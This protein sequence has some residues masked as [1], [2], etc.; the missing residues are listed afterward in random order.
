[1]PAWRSTERVCTP[2][3]CKLS[4]A[5]TCAFPGSVPAQSTERVCTLPRCKLYTAGSL[6]LARTLSTPGAQREF[7]LCP[8][9]NFPKQSGKLAPCPAIVPAWSSTERVCTRPRC[10]L[11]RA[12]S[13]RLA[14]P[15]SLPRAQRRFGPRPT[16]N[17][18][19][20]EARVLPGLSKLTDCFCGDNRR[21]AR[22]DW[23]AHTH[24]QHGAL[25]SSGCACECGPVPQ[26]QAQLLR[27]R[28][29]QQSQQ[30]LNAHAHLLP[31]SARPLTNAHIQTPSPLSYI[32]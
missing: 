2:S 32:K 5:G 3:C 25:S 9:A 24:P 28:E 1:M 29:A 15:L 7:A 13:P 19:E 16:V 8:A 17:F 10:K 31:S 23:R 22:C 4:I 26:F 21:I 11:S 6:C 18:T 30:S 14:G 27:A 12:G 20:Q